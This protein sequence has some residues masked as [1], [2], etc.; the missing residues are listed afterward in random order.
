[1]NISLKILMFLCVMVMAQRAMAQL[2]IREGSFKQLS[3]SEVSSQNG[4]LN[5]GDLSALIDGKK[6]DDNGILCAL[7]KVRVEKISRSDIA[8][9]EFRVNAGIQIVEKRPLNGEMWVHITGAETELLITHPTFGA[10]NKVTVRLE[11]GKVYELRLTNGETADLT[12]MSKPAGASIFL[13][14][15]FIGRATEYGFSQSKVPY[16][17]HTV[18]AEYDG[19]AEEKTVEVTEG[20]SRIIWFNVLHRKHFSFDST[21]KGATLFVDDIKAGATPASIELTLEQHKIKAVRGGQADSLQ[22]DFS[23]T[24]ET[25]FTFNFE[26]KQAAKASE[27]PATTPKLDDGKRTRWPFYVVGGGLV[28]AGGAFKLLSNSEHDKYLAATAQS[29]MD[30]HYNK[31]VSYN[32]M[33]YVGLTA[34]ATLIVYDLIKGPDRRPKNT[35]GFYYN[36]QFKAPGLTF[37]LNF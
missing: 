15:N 33:F 17:P 19:I 13:D 2:E 6:Y 14:N 22:L 21:P 10:S 35:A 24:T 9:L 23:K 27:T 11:G 4:Q 31:S 7:L 5:A 29:D 20:S 16:G 1:M 26:K 36:P 28:A 30:A 37:T 18:R 8:K 34:G 25:A 32:T 3:R 12:F